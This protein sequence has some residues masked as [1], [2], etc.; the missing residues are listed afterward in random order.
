M[1]NKFLDI[2]KAIEMG[3]TSLGIELGSTRIKAVLIGDDHQP[4]AT[5]NHDWENSYINGVWT[6]ELD[7]VWKGL[8]ASYQAL[9]RDV[10]SKYEVTLTR[11]GAIGIS[12]MMHGYMVF[13]EAGT[14]LTPFR[15]WRNNM[16]GPASQAL[17]K[18]FDYPI[19]QRWGIA[20]LYQ[21]ILNDEPHVAKID[22]MTTLSGYLHWQ[23]TGEKVLGVGE[24]SG[25]FPIDLNTK[26]F[27]HVFFDRF[28]QAVSHKKYPWKI[29]EIMPRVDVAGQQAGVLTEAGAKRLDITGQLESGIPMCPPEGDAGTGMVA[30]NSVSVG[31][32]NVS[33]GTSVFAMIVLEKELSQ[34]Y[35][36]LD[37]VTTPD[38]HLVAMAHSNNCTSDLDAWFGLFSEVTRCLGTGVSMNTLYQNLLQEALK[39]DPDCGGLLA[40]GYLSGEHVTHFEEGRPLF[41]RSAN[42]AF[43]LANFVRVHLFTA[44]GAM[45]T[46]LDILFEKEQVKVHEIK[47]HGGFFKTGDVGQKVMAAATNTPVSTLETAGEGGAW[48]IAILGA[49]MQW[50]SEDEALADYLNK[51]IFH[52][53]MGTCVQ[54][55]PIDVAGYNQFYARYHKGLAIE[56]A[57]VEVLC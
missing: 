25:A 4:I 10:Q 54:P 50:R 38:G 11:V 33:A 44:L 24:A 22:F 1:D 16:T 2:K 20:H 43:N 56:R 19:P 30:T 48:G 7:D 27:N 5:G 36:E 21:A 39:G 32:G 41:V 18:L 45:R 53:K 3:R 14:L 46:G 31:T 57:A 47:G 15:T 37:L 9:T 40:Y 29:E 13:D 8:Q 42:S 35:S 52:D 28:N 6:Y 51:R 34:V 23:L 26:S 12:G 49:Y 55:D 17:S